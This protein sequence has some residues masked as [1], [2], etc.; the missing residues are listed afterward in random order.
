MGKTVDKLEVDANVEAP[1]NFVTEALTSG[2]PRLREITPEQ[3]ATLCA[4]KADAQPPTEAL[5]RAAA[6]PRRFQFVPEK[7]I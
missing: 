4:L 5:R 2:T 6:R 1:A 7:E 3:A